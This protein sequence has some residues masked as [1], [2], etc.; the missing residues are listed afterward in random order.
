VTGPLTQRVLEYT[1]VMKRLVPVAHQPSDWE[2]LAGFVAVEH[3][4]RVG[5]FLE[6]Q[7]WAQYTE[8]MCQ[9]AGSIDTFDT[10]VRR[11]AEVDGLVYFEIEERHTRGQRTDAVNSLTV[12]EFDADA[13]IRGLSVYLQQAR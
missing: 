7:D 3:F 5:T 4:S 12:F 1:D 6:R 10:E 2:P 11:V 9:W 8:M 13:R